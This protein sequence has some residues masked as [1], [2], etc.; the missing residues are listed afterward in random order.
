MRPVLVAVD[1]GAGNPVAIGY[2]D[3]YN[4]QAVE[5]LGVNV[6]VTDDLMAYKSV[7]NKLD[8]EHQICQFHVRRWVGRTLQNL[9]ETVPKEWLWVLDEIR[10]L[11]DEL[12]AE[13]SR[14]LFELWKQ[15][16]GRRFVRKG[17][18]LLWNSYVT[19]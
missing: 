14:R 8:L 10:H 9:Q 6:L 1:L 7:A 17:L 3:E 19:C 11:L 16:P 12:P 15:I 13:G 4:P 18:V 5:R 2:V